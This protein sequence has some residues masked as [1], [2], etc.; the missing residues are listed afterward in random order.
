MNFVEYI[1]TA[2]E[3]L[4]TIAFSLSGTLV[5]IDRGLDLFGVSVL[6]VTTAVGGG[7]FRDILLG[8]T[9]P[10]AFIDPKFVAI[11]FVAAFITILW[12]RRYI[13]TVTPEKMS[14]FMIAIEIGRAQV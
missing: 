3:I 6:G 7:I 12:A 2:I 1:I 10:T 8:K 9:P 11:A 13:K 14:K 5:G 4:G